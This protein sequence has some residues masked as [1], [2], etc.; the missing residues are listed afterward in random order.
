[1]SY[2]VDGFGKRGG[3]SLGTFAGMSWVAGS[4]FVLA[5]PRWEENSPGRD[6][7]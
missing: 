2:T 1:M 7:G 5:A 6:P 4:V 3:E